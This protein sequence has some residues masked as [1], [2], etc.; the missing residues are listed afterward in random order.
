MSDKVKLWCFLLLLPFFA[1]IGHDLYVNF[2][3]NKENK[4]RLEAFE[5]DPTA[6]QGSDFGYLFIKYVPGFYEMSRD[7]IG[8][9][10]WTKWIDPVLRL[11]TFVVALI[12]ATAFFIWLLFARIFDLWPYASGGGGKR[13]DAGEDGFGRRGATDTTFKYKRR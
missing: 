13:A 3:M 6:Y 12:P 8:E 10:F 11:Y 9:S 1:A 4:A 7:M 2:Y 5:I